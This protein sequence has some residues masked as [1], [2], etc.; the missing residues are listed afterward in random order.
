MRKF[1]LS[2]LLWT[3]GGTLYFFGEVAWKTLSHAPDKISWV[4]LLTAIILCIPLERVGAELPWD[5]PLTLQSVLC[6]FAIT[7]IEFIVGLI[8]NVGLGMNIWDYSNLPYNLMG[9]IC[10]Q[11]SCL[12]IVISFFGII[13]FDVLRYLVEGG[14]RPH[15][16][17]F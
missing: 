4:M 15:Y 10:L 8:C 16:T 5:M 7:V 6:G 1:I 14:E 9:Q 13:I 3:W 17:L 11:F 2:M 12:W